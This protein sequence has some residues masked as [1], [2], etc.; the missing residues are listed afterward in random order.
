MRHDP[1]TPDFDEII[2]RRGT[3]CSKWDQM[4]AVYGV[5]PDDGIAMWVADM[6]FRPP[7]CVQRAVEEM[8]AHGFTTSGMDGIAQILRA[9]SSGPSTTLFMAQEPGRKERDK[10]QLG[11][12]ECPLSPYLKA[13]KVLLLKEDLVFCGFRADDGEI[14][15]PGGKAH[16]GEGT[17]DC[18]VRELEEELDVAGTKAPA[19]RCSR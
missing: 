17:V 2:D 13:S 15:F 6:D 3:N 5:S 8:A 18:A 10:E 16:T 9:R 14:D 7:A 19:R 1:T 12:G 4:Q 11:G